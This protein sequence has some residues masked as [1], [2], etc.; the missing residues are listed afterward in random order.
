MGEHSHDPADS[1]LAS[2][3]H[4]PMDDMEPK[5]LMRKYDERSLANRA[6]IREAALKSIAIMN[7]AFDHAMHADRPMVALWQAAFAIGLACCDGITMTRAG[8]ICGVTRACIS[9]GARQFCKDNELEPSFYMK[10][11][12][13][14]EIARETREKQ[15]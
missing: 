1:D 12:E 6:A 14:A 2:Y 11:D 5:V 7:R 4:H 9:K 8:E 13:A 15:L 3:S 10:S